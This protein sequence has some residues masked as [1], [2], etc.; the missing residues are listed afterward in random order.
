MNLPLPRPHAQRVGTSQ[1]RGA[2]WQREGR[3]SECIL[4]SVPVF[5]V[6]EKRE[7]RGQGQG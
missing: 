7:E 2:R 3:D 4:F 5:S 6:L 1:R